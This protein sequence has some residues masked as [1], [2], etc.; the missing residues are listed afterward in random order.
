MTQRIC[1]LAAAH[2]EHQT[3]WDQ[4]VDELSAIASAYLRHGETESQ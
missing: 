1:M 2:V 3:D 4:L